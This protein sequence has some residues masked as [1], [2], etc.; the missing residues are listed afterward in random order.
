MAKVKTY[1]TIGGVD[2]TSYVLRYE[3]TDKFNEDIPKCKLVL[4]WSVGTVITP[5]N[6]PYV[7][8]KRG[9]T[10][11]QEYNVFKGYIT[12]VKL[13]KP[14]VEMTISGMLVKLIQS[15]ITKSFDINIDTEAGVASEIVKTMIN[16]YTVLSADSSSVVSTGTSEVID[17]FVCIET[18]VYERIEAIA[19]IYGYQF[20]YNLDD[21]LVYFEPEGYTTNGTNLEVG[22]NVTN[23]P[24][25]VYDNSQ[26]IN[27][28][29]INGAESM[30][31]TTET[32]QIGV[33]SGYTT[34]SVQLT[35]SPFSVK[36]FADSSSPP[37]T[38]RIGG[39]DSST[40]DHEYEVDRET[41][42]IVWNTANYT[43]GASDY[44]EVLYTYPVPVPVI[45]RDTASISA[46]G[47]S[48][49]VK[50]FSDIKT[51]EDATNRATLFLSTY[52]TPFTSLKCNVTDISNDYR[53]GQKVTVT[54]IINDIE[55]ELVITQIKRK[56]PH[57]YDEIT[58]GDKEYTIAAY[59]N[60]MIDRIKRIEEE[61]TKNTDLVNQIFDFERVHK[62]SERRYMALQTSSVAGTTLIWGHPTFGTW[63]TY[64]WGSS[65]FAS[66]ILGSSLYGVLGTSVLGS[67]FSTPVTIKLVQGK[68]T[69]DEYCYDTEFHN[70]TDSTATFDTGNTRI[71]FTAGQVWYSN[72]IDI[73]SQLTHA[74]V[75]FGDLTGTV[76][77]E[78][79]A[80]SGVTWQTLTQ[81]TRTTLT[82]SD[83]TSCIL[84][85]TESGGSTA[86][87]EPTTDTYGER[88]FPAI[89]CRMEQ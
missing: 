58:V 60:A 38:L 15:S 11:G 1:V 31:E 81:A 77:I 56:F 88:T 85:I 18:D 21:D 69:Y 46:Y 3:A 86:R 39:V 48:S 80:D 55:E 12:A 37:T 5:E 57:N 61:F 54:D 16:D 74:T 64:R 34:T 9:Y 26:L 13:N 66:F 42:Q 70:S 71:D 62:T 29:R 20:Y 65:A 79:S 22:V 19:G 10:T 23:V 27:K 30:V 41:N 50:T 8:I 49:T 47:E 75:T 35:Q 89:R 51:V 43:P 53:V 7:E 33:T 84:R 63:G 78:I 83:G 52:S 82:S 73:G 28:V 36:V 67:A 72:P 44:V 32:G 6:G 14:Y 87:I 25:W 59:N 68:M 45:R 40:G 24:T 17:K 2:V 76:T 4:T